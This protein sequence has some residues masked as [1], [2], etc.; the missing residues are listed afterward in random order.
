MIVT[1]ITVVDLT[2]ARRRPLLARL[3]AIRI[4]RGGVVAIV[5]AAGLVAVVAFVLSGR[6]SQVHHAAEPGYGERAAVARAL[7]YPYPLRCL[8]IAVF[9]DDP[10]YATAEIDQSNSCA[11]YRGDIYASLHRIDG[12]W[13][14]ILDEGQLYVDESAVPTAGSGGAGYPLGCLSARTLRQD[15]AFASAGSDR[16]VCAQPR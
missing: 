5:L 14:L 4:R 2:P 9:A 15:R 10:T 12:T 3:T 13:R 16:G 1:S 6:P 8:T 11:R 7:G